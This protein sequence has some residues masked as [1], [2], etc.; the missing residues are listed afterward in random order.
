M[1]EERGLG[2]AQA[3]RRG[4]CYCWRALQ[5]A[6]P[7]VGSAA[8]RHPHQRSYLDASGQPWYSVYLL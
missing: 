3:H 4:G 1:P 7:S 2:R 8:R 6:D 5:F